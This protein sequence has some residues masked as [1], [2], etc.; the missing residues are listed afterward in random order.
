LSNQSTK[1]SVY[2][3][4]SKQSLKLKVTSNSQTNNKSINPNPIKNKPK[5]I[6][7]KTLKHK[8]KWIGLSKIHSTQEISHPVK[9]PLKTHKNISLLTHKENIP[10]KNIITIV[11]SP[12]TFNVK[13]KMK[14][15]S[16]NNN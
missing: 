8:T 11:S 4:Y 15:N 10:I 7:L 5:I 3:K 2:K 1:S 6:H 16:K 13:H 14:I 12:I 9:I